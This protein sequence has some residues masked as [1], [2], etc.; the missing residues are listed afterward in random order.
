LAGLHHIAYGVVT[1]G[2]VFGD[3][4]IESSVFRGREPDENRYNIETGRLDSA[5]VRLFV[6]PHKDW[7]LQLSRGH[8]KSPEESHP[9]VN[10][11]RTTASAIYN[12]SFGQ[13]A[14]R[15]PSPGAGM[16]RVRAID[17]CVSARIRGA[18]GQRKPS[19]PEPSAPTRTNSSRRE[20]RW[21]IRHFASG[22]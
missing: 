18:D 12:R 5:S 6:Q 13:R 19:S 8:L 21:P 3:M 1:L 11:D 7:A 17:Q 15:R 22:S 14:R 10:I 4:K 20:T 9:D 16:R 2:Y